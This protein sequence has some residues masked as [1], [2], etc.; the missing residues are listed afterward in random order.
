MSRLY[1]EDSI[2]K[3]I[4]YICIERQNLTHVSNL[5]IDVHWRRETNDDCIYKLEI[6]R[7]QLLNESKS[8]WIGR[9]IR[10]NKQQKVEYYNEFII[11]STL[12]CQIFCDTCF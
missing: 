10:I 8:P 1:Y 3:Q 4:N 7:Y 5:N 2:K 12:A 6:R 11:P 9:P